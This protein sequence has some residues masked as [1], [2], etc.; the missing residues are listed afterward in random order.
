M[1]IVYS[2]PHS[3]RTN[4][5]II[6]EA[7]FYGIIDCVKSIYSFIIVLCFVW[8]NCV[9]RLDSEA[10]SD[11]STNGINPGFK[12]FLSKCNYKCLEI[13]YMKTVEIFLAVI[14]T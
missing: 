9:H 11:E 14:A 5:I 10:G 7:R 3:S 12:W 6:T 13:N 2:T 8:E 1:N 4:D